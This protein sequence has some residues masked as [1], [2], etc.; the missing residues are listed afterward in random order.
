MTLP[1]QPLVSIDIVPF[2]FRNGVLEVVLAKRIFEPFLGKAA[3][4]GVL[5][6]PNE[7][8][9]E[10]AVRALETKAGI[11]Q[12]SI[13]SITGAGVFDNPD[14]DPRGPTLS[15]VHAVILDPEAPAT[16]GGAV[17]VRAAE[18]KDLPFD[19]VAIIARTAGAVLDALWIDRALTRALLGDRFTTASAA[20]LVRELAA[21][22][23]RPEPVTNNLGRDLAKSSWFIKTTPAAAPSGRGRPA[24]EWG[25]S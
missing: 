16:G 6:S 21:A 17:P 5:L 25:W 8:L 3:L 19:H 11:G 23:K 20:R 7:R 24:A 4:P 15:I 9:A 14:R 1:Q 13:R 2:V 18:V 10:A 12:E 22:A